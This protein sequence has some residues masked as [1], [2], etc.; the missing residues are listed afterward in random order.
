MEGRPLSQIPIFLGTVISWKFIGECPSGVHLPQRPNLRLIPEAGRL[1]VCA[2][3][4]LDGQRLRR[5]GF[6]V[7]S[8]YI[9]PLAL[10]RSPQPESEQPEL[11]TSLSNQRRPH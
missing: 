11:E 10:L 8:E 3:A 5:L 2:A 6:R 4:S 1:P 7:A 9:G